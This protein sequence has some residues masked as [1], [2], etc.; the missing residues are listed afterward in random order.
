M[1][2]ILFPLAII[3]MTT[4]LLSLTIYYILL[5]LTIYYIIIIYYILLSL[6]IYNILLSLTTVN[7]EIITTIIFNDF[8]NPGTLTSLNNNV[9]KVLFLQQ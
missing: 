8:S 7:P 1:Y 9:F 3:A 5:S 4:I 2:Y 6:T